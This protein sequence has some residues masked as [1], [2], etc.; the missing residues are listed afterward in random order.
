[1]KVQAEIKNPEYFL[2][3]G[4]LVYKTFN[5]HGSLCFVIMTQLKSIPGREQPSIDSILSSDTHVAAYHRGVAWFVGELKEE[6]AAPACQK[7][8]QRMLQSPLTWK[9]VQHAPQ[10]LSNL[11]CSKEKK[12]TIYNFIFPIL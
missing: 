7:L 11:E 1:M 10:T 3:S 6:S 12:N 2:A 9:C 8:R 5:V 4:T